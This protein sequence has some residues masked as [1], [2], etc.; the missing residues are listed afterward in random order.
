MEATQRP[1]AVVPDQR[2]QSVISP[3]ECAAL[4][5]NIPAFA[6]LPPDATEELA[7]RLLEERYSIGDVVVEE[8]ETGDRLYIIAEGQAEAATS[9]PTGPVLLGT[10]QR[11]ELFG[12]IALLSAHALRQATVTADTALTALSLDASDFHEVL[13][14]YPETRAAFEA[15]DEELLVVKFLKQASP[16]A[17][18]DLERARHLAERLEPTSVSPGDDIVREGERGDSCYL[19]RSGRVEVLVA[20]EDG[21]HRRLDTLGPGTIVGESALL[22]EGPRNAT[23]RATEPCELLVLHRSDL[24]DTATIDQ[25]ASQQMMRLIRLRGRP[26]RAEDIIVQHRPAPDGSVITTLKNPRRAVYYRLSPQGFFVWERLD[27]NHTL[28]DLALEYMSVFKHFAPQ[29]I[30]EVVDGL[31]ASGFLESDVV[32]QDVSQMVS[33]RPWRS[34]ALSTA[35]HLIDWRVPLRNIDTPLGALYRS[36]VRLLFTFPGQIALALLALIG[37]GAFVLNLGRAGSATSSGGWVLVFFLAMYAVAVVLHESGHAFAVKAFGHE[38]RR[39]GVGWYWFGPIAY[40]D[41]SDMWLDGRWPRIAVSLAGPYATVLVAGISSLLASALGNS[42]IAA[43]LWQLAF[44][45][46]YL[47]LVNFNPLMEYDG[48]FIL[49]DWLER[50]NLR[51]QC[52]RWIGNELPAALRNRTELARHRLELFFGLGAV[53]YVLAI[54]FLMLGVYRRVVQGWLDHI[55]PLVAASTIA[56]ILTL[57]L[58]SLTLVTIWGDMRWARQPST[59]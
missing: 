31:E 15:S 13:A 16:F 11:G 39:A 4:L 40:V 49:M 36:G 5:A 54:G 59:S 27:G 53:L 20:C 12:E 34:R 44:L 55:M 30:A 10:Y 51:Q 17:K 58:V 37:L 1:A 48:Y 57:G 7:A 21:T 14:R 22:V 32:R 9:S 41:T 18:L 47:V 23:V 2:S 26:R 38:I 56:W 52:L 35:R 8:G 19:L 45:S 42:V 28:R 29:A 3:A 50:P 46:Y 6:S 43:V 33:R 25:Q 24:L